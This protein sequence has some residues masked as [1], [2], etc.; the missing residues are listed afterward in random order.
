M[1]G[2]DEVTEPCELVCRVGD[3]TER[4]FRMRHLFRRR[5]V[6]SA[7]SNAR[8]NELVYSETF[9]T[10]SEARIISPCKVRF[11]LP[12]EEVCTPYDRDGTACCF[13][14]THRMTDV[15]PLEFIEISQVPESFKQG[16]EPNDTAIPK[17]KGLDLFCGGGNFGRG[18]EEA[19]FMDYNW[20]NDIS[21]DAMR[22]YMANVKPGSR[23]KPFVGSIDDLVAST[24]KGTS[25]DNIPSIG[26][27]D[28]ISGGSPCQ[29]FS[30]LTND[31]TAD[32][33]LKNQS[34]VAAFASCVD[35]HRPR[36]GVL[37]NVTG[38]IQNNQH[39]GRDVCSQLIC[40]L[41]GMGYQL[42]LCYT[43]A[44]SFGASQRRGRIF[45]VF[46]RGGLELPK[47][48]LE[49]H[50]TPPTGYVRS[51]GRLPT[52]EGMIQPGD[53][54]PRPFRFRSAREECKDLP[55]IHDGKVDICVPF[56]DHRIPI[57]MTDTLQRRVVRIP[58]CPYGMNFSKA[59]YGEGGVNGAKP[60][61]PY[62]DGTV[63]SDS[64]H[65]H[66]SKTALNVSRQSNML[67]RMYPDRLIET[68][69]TKCSPM[70]A[71]HGRVL[72]WEEPRVISLMEARRAQGFRD[73]EIILGTPDQA[74]RIVGNS[75]P[76]QVALALG[77]SFADAHRTKLEIE[78]GNPAANSYD[79]DK[80]KKLVRRHPDG[81]SEEAE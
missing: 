44:Y 52:G 70:D 36:Y 54:R 78:L 51:F 59:F 27:V 47:P 17:L 21:H 63:F 60:V 13:F 40:A 28:F 67:G 9:V 14:I 37:E 33:Q 4:G 71:K 80:G 64:L 75:V 8:P 41:V 53:D 73:E 25:R 2:L 12:G 18:L 48:P 79:T 38:I 55:P 76:R 1:N 6:D 74:Y 49:S 20:A 7:A 35:I 29:G 58:I 50:T 66:S 22:T 24:L 72:H 34:L 31:K 23:I 77:V 46:T 69:V 5:D 62:S 10:I 19:G 26:E 16:Y 39:R 30:A 42:R 32:V 61:I 65:V 57:G 56:P 11:F 81:S 15:P 68:I 45:I 3:D 43:E